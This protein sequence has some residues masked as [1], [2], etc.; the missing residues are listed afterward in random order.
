MSLEKNRVNLAFEKMQRNYYHELN[1]V[2]ERSRGLAKKGTPLTHVERGRHIAQSSRTTVK[3]NV[4]SQ[5]QASH[6][7]KFSQQAKL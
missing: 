4:M 6:L 7:M 1:I 3:L 5:V 2:T